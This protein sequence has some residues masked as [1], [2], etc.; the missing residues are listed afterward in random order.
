VN[1][2]LTLKNRISLKNSGSETDEIYDLQRIA[3]ILDSPPGYGARLSYLRIQMTL[4]EQ[5]SFFSTLQDQLVRRADERHYESAPLQE[6]MGRTLDRVDEVYN[7]VASSIEYDVLGD[8]RSPIGD[9]SIASLL[10][11]H[12]AVTDDSPMPSEVRGIFRSVPV[13][14]AD[15]AGGKL[16]SPS[17]PEQIVPELKK[18]LTWWREEYKVLA[19]N[20]VQ[21]AVVSTLSI[22]HWKLAKT[23]PFVDGNGR[24][25]RFILNRASEELLQ[26]RIDRRLM[27]DRKTYFG[28]LSAAMSG[29]LTQLRLLISA[30]LQ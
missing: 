17:A 19:A 1:Q 11:I 29:D 26:R 18:T 8:V 23:H 25:I 16:D 9:L 28:A 13:W 2:H 21:S 4:E 15:G 7:L 27:Q 22:L 5:V 6:M 24:V 12:S 20:P 10:L 3:S 14:I 30:A